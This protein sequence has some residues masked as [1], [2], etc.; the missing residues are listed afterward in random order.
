MTYRVK[1]WRWRRTLSRHEWRVVQYRYAEQV[2]TTSTREGLDYNIRPRLTLF[3]L[4]PPDGPRP[5][6]V[7]LDGTLTMWGRRLRPWRQARSGVAWLAGDLSSAFIVALPGPGRF[8][9]ARVG[10]TPG[11]LRLLRG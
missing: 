7:R 3:D 9:G 11:R 1:A 2:V 8:F 10:T 4:P 5:L 6:E